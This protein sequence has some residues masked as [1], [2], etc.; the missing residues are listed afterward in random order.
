MVSELVGRSNH[1]PLTLFITI[2]AYTTATPHNDDC[3]ISMR[4]GIEDFIMQDLPSLAGRISRL[5]IH[6]DS[7]LTHS[8][9]LALNLH[10]LPALTTID[11]GS[12]P[13]ISPLNVAAAGSPADLVTPQLWYRH[14]VKWFTT[15]RTL[16]T[17]KVV[18]TCAGLWV[19]PAE[20]L[21]VLKSNP[22]IEVVDIQV[23]Q[24]INI[25]HNDVHDDSTIYLPKLRHLS[26]GHGPE[27]ITDILIGI[28]IPRTTVSHIR[29][30]VDDSDSM[31]ID[32]HILMRL[33]EVLCK[34][35]LPGA[36]EAAEHHVEISTSMS[37]GGRSQATLHSSSLTLEYN[38]TVR[39]SEHTYPGLSLDLL[40]TTIQGLFGSCPGISSLSLLA[41]VDSGKIRSDDATRL[42]RDISDILPSITNM[43]LTISARDARAF[44]G[45]LECPRDFTNMHSVVWPQL[46]RFSAFWI[47]EPGHLACSKTPLTSRARGGPVIQLDVTAGRRKICSQ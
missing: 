15:L 6:T 44:F 12:V 35:L 9:F 42:L 7:M 22:N 16:T 18:D 23:T 27:Y 24:R 1:S 10:P 4:R 34:T 13:H 31:C 41:S 2:S 33:N 45:A 26:V 21:S 36:A 25:R 17:L 20:L 14:I 43:Q 47:E 11:I 38:S 8:I 39:W 40:C 29:V 28:S 3:R 37:C 32:Y 46:T 19:A 5:R 30:H